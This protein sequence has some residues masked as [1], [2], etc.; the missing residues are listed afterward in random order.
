MSASLI[1]DNL[2]R[3]FQLERST[4]RGR[5]VRLGDLVD[6]VL[7]RH[8]YPEPVGRLLG[9]LFVLAATLAGGLKFNGTFS[10]QIRSDGPVS[11]MLADCTN[12]G[13]MRGYARYDE[14]AVAA[15]SGSDVEALLGQ[16]HLAF[17]VDQN[18]AGQAYQGIVELSGPTLTDCMQAY[19]RQSQQIQTGLK[20]A[21]DRIEAGE[22]LRWRAGGI[23]IQRVADEAK[24]I[25][26]EER[27]TE[28]WR[29]TMLL[30]A[31]ATAAELI[32]PYLPPERL[33]LHL[34]H[35]E[36][37]RVFTPLNLRFGCRC[38]RE[39]VEALLRRFPEDELDDMKDDD[40]EVVVTCQF[41]NVDFRFDDA[42]LA[43]LHGRLH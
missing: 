15:A 7:T 20:I 39:R 19:F 9:E 23:M 27:A 6:Q 24:D 21:V 30:L 10:L 26:G 38:T 35:E 32:D 34:F 33:L 25:W 37:V 36:G 40:G 4:L 29:R 1:A 17:T 41:C 12:D 8:D 31:T 28:D 2:L 11:L 5:V 14:A 22:G 3:P 42:Q 13:A 16:G 43:R 18:E